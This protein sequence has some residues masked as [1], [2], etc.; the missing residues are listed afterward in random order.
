MLEAAKIAIVPENAPPEIIEL[1]D[2]TI[3]ANEEGG[4]EQ[5]PAIL[6]LS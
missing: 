1:A 3:P 6:G 2:A 4:W 5:L